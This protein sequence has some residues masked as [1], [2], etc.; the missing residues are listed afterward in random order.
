[1]PSSAPVTLQAACETGSACYQ[2]VMAGVH[3]LQKAAQEGLH[4]D[5]SQR[6]AAQMCCIIEHLWYMLRQQ[7][8]AVYDGCQHLC[9]AQH[10]VGLLSE[11]AAR[12]SVS[13]RSEHETQKLR[14]A[15]LALYLCGTLLSLNFSNSMCCCRNALSALLTACQEINLCLQQMQTLCPCAALLNSSSLSKA[16]RSAKEALQ[17]V[18]EKIGKALSDLLKLQVSGSLPVQ[19]SCHTGHPLAFGT[20]LVDAMVRMLQVLQEGLVDIQEA[21]RTAVPDLDAPEMP[22]ELIVQHVYPS[23]TALES[24]MS[25]Q[26]DKAARACAAAGPLQNA[27]DSTATCSTQV[28]AAECPQEMVQLF[29]DSIE[30]SI[31][32]SLT[33][34]QMLQTQP[35]DTSQDARQCMAP[36]AVQGLIACLQASSLKQLCS[37]LAACAEAAGQVSGS[38]AQVVA[39]S[40]QMHT[41]L[42][43]V[44]V[45]LAGV[46]AALAHAV[47]LQTASSQ[48]AMV[49]TC[50]FMAYVKDGFGEGEG[51]EQDGDGDG[52]GTS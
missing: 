46:R 20:Q 49:L 13:F 6:E 16:F 10:L 11:L 38:S 48:L 42:H 30:A 35:W 52:G 50:V 18:T 47:V 19:H 24:L 51:Q 29:A 2:R 17:S 40:S 3:V 33:W 22:K 28:D 31:Q 34:A 23:W 41:M 12:P 14:C 21:G 37:S 1:M 44:R 39:L 45:V 26:V 25:T 7:Q 43:L 36:Q 27:R 32:R 4:S 8:N 9:V 5:I 15:H